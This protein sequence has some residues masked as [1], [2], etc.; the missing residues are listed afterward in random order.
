M[1]R[2]Q[3]MQ[4]FKDKSPAH[5]QIELEGQSSYD[6]DRDDLARLGKKQVLKR[7]FGFMS[8]LGFSCTIM[9]TWEGML[10]YVT[11]QPFRLQHPADKHLVSSSP[12]FRM[13]V[14]LVSSTASL[15][16]G[17][18]PCVSSPPYL[19]WSLWLQRQYYWVAMLAP[20][21]SRR[22]LSYITG[23]LTV[24]GWQALT[25]SGAFLCGTLIQGLIALTHPEYNP[26][27]WHGTLLLWS[28]IL[29]A[30][31]VNTIISSLLPKLECLILIIHVLGF[32][33][34]LIPLV[35]MAPHGDAASVFTVFLNE[36]GWQTTGLSFMIGLTG[37]V[38]AFLGTDAAIHM[39]EEISNASL[40]VPRS[41]L[42]SVM[43]NGTLGFAMLIAVLFCLGDIEQVI[44]TNTG[45]PFMAIFQNATQSAGGAAAM[46]SV[47]VTL[48]ICATIAFL[49]SSSRMTW[50]FARD[51]GLPLSK[52]LGKVEPRSSIPLIA[53]ITTVIISILLSLINIGSS[54]AFNQVISLTINSLYASYF[55]ACALLLQRRLDG[56]ISSA[57]SAYDDPRG[58]GSKQKIITIGSDN[59]DGEPDIVN[60]TWGPFR[61]PGA[62]GVAVNVAALVYM[63]V[64]I[65]FSFWP[66]LRPTTAENMN[67]SVLVTGFVICFSI[68]YYLVYA[69]K[70]Y[71][72]PL[73]EV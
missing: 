57:P 7:N 46:A 48:G 25:A 6:R 45:Y 32:F 69:K 30:V 36:G 26:Q 27:R 52:Y 29:V 68:V 21:S 20:P 3:E 16:P 10:V 49:A 40:N 35:Y 22:F 60:L 11:I 31:I 44:E 55:L 53:I 12:D 33:A 73:V 50:S 70:T 17:L 43:L 15:L 24:A 62:L 4:V 14:P 34:V 2:P 13:E 18:G 61:V 58:G 38:F 47:V 67:Y 1:N 59:S 5:T 39:S 37:N 72:G 54:T 65:F 71:K 64:I 56:S 23:F 66:P 28:V 42:A 63:A 9:V 8:M 41:M 19:N 51:R